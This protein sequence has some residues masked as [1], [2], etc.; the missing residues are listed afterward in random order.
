MPEVSSSL[1]GLVPGLDTDPYPWVV[2]TLFLVGVCVFTGGIWK[3]A[4]HG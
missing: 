4:Y 1:P 2:V 3:S